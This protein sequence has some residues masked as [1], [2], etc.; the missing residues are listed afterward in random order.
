MKRRE[1]IFF[2]QTIE[3]SKVLIYL[4]FNEIQTSFSPCLNYVFYS[5]IQFFFVF[6]LI[7][8]LSTATN[9]QIWLVPIDQAPVP[10]LRGGQGGLPPPL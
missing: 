7:L 6:F 4:I 2:A 10:S 5:V 3:N 1:I 8:K 9:G